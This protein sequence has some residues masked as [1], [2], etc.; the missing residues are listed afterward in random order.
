MIS[1][2]WRREAMS[3]HLT[4]SKLS[5]RELFGTVGKAL[6]LT[7][8]IG[9]AA[10]SSANAAPSASLTGIAGIDRVTVL[11]GK[12]YLRGWTG[13]GD[14][15][16]PGRGGGRGYVPPPVE[17]GPTPTVTWSKYSG[18]GAVTVADEHAA[19]TTAN[20]SAPGD[21]VLRFSAEN[22]DESS[23]S[24]FNVSVQPPPP[25]QKLDAVYTKNFKIDS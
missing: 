6:V 20:C 25:A 14:Q 22:G 7:P 8:I 1:Y 5:R 4:N 18:P 24:T 17:T 9:S 2:F 12:T 21:S 16:Q 10:V 19:I 3:D 11:G 15:P 23:A 13:Y